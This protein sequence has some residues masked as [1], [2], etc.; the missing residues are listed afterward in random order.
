MRGARSRLLVALFALLVG[1]VLTADI[2]PLTVR[3]TSPMG[4]TG[5]LGAVRIV[6]QVGHA[7]DSPLQSVKFFVNHTLVGED[8][9]GP[10]Y[11]VEWSDDNP[12][13]PTEIT[14]EATDASGRT[15]RD[16]VRLEP[17]EI[18]DETRVISVQI[19]RAHV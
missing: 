3:I 18:V 8:G 19:G 6:A 12:F 17:F 7:E 14:V 5:T 11:A 10:I 9:E 1:A 2:A 13:E 4:R 15:A 16:A